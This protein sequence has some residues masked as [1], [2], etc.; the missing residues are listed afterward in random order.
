MGWARQPAAVVDRP[1][2]PVMSRWLWVA[3]LAV[4]AGLLLFLLHV[5][6]P[7][8]LMRAFNIWVFSGSP[9]LTWVLAFGARAYTYGRALAHYRFLEEQAQEAQQSWQTW[10]QRYMAVS[11]SCVLLPD[12]VSASLLAQGSSGLPPC[13]G[14]ARRIAA[15]PAHPDR[16]RYGLQMLIQAVAPALKTLPVGQELRL[17]LLS[18]VGAAQYQTLRDALQQVWCATVSRTLPTTITLSAELSYSWVDDTLRNASTAMELILVLQV[19]GAQTYSD[20]LA[21]LLLCPDR[22]ADAL[23][24]PITAGLL[25]PM[26]LDINMLDSE[27][28]LLLQTQIRAKEAPALLADDAAWQPLTSKILVTA[29][30]HGASL[31]VEQQWVQEALCGL[32]GPL[33]HWLVTALGVEVVRHQRKPLLV[34]VGEKSGHWVS[35]VTTGEL[36]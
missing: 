7:M 22:L 4:L 6:E 18:D 30:A 27:L 5:S 15:L 10:A 1:E 2:P 9:L 34:L 28:P 14:R 33:G 17:T 24:L 13:T 11:A 26:P 31:K 29:G 16:A 12:D 25:R 20:G 35:T 36:A 8:P 3:A 23:A 19:N 21:V 32:P